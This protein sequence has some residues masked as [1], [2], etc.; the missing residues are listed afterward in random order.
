MDL[1]INKNDRLK[2]RKKFQNMNSFR[3]PWLNILKSNVIRISEGE[4]INMEAETT[5]TDSRHE[6][7][8]RTN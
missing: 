5:F 2:K 3:N 7:T 4:E 6:A 1:E 8:G